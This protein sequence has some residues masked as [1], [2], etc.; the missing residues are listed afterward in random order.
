MPDQDPNTATVVAVQVSAWF[1]AKV[2]ASPQPYP[3]VQEV[4][5][6]PKVKG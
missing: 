3:W 5:H 6:R 4:A 2:L 1:L